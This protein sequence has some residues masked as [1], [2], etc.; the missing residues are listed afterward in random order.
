MWVKRLALAHPEIRFALAG[1]DR[2]PVDYPAVVGDGALL[3][4]IG[5]VIGDDFA[6]NS[7][8]VDAMREGVH[9]GGFAGLPTF[10]RGNGLAQYF[11]VNGRPV[12]DRQLLGALR[13]AY[14]DVMKRERHPWRRS[15]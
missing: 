11:F 9:L 12:K 10:S 4:R 1:E 15:S 14:A 8:A 2:V 3:T 13:A 6:R 7:V 5:Q